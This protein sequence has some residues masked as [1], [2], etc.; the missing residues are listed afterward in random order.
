M[1]HIFKLSHGQVDVYGVGK[2]AQPG[3][4]RFGE[5]V[6]TEGKAVH[7]VGLLLA[8]ESGDEVRVTVAVC[9]E[10]TFEERKALVA[11]LEAIPAAEGMEL[12]GRFGVWT[13]GWRVREA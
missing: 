5:P 12:L 10:L 7:R 4:L 13:V 6:I 2:D 11:Y 8:E 3:E 9:A 1:F